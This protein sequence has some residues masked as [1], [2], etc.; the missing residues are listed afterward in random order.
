MW[1][2]KER[3]A[4]GTDHD[5]LIRI[6]ENIKFVR[7]KVTT[8]LAEDYQRFASIDSRLSVLE[9]LRWQILGGV[10]VAVAITEWVSKLLVKS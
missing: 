2:G 1:D 4:M 10:I 7:E 6:D 3:R 8:H 5:T 9:K